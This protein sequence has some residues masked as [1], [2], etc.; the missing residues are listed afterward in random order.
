MKLFIWN[1]LIKRYL[2]ALKFNAEVFLQWAL[3]PGKTGKSIDP[4]SWWDSLQKISISTLNLLHKGAAD[5]LWKA[6][7]FFPLLIIVENKN[8]SDLAL[9]KKCLEFA[10][11]WI[12]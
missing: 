7:V 1:N 4:S 10:N 2:Y 12:T 9:N 6:K 3:G 8:H 5:E 11:W